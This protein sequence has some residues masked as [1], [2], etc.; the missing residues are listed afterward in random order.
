MVVVDAA[1]VV[2]IAVVVAVV[3][4]VVVSAVNLMSNS[5]ALKCHTKS[6]VTSNPAR[7]NAP[8]SL[9]AFRHSTRTT[10]KSLCLYE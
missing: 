5:E 3:V 4:V 9:S 7:L 8:C 10:D 6:S 1:V 2:V